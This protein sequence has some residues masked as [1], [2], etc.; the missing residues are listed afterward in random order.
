VLN[1]LQYLEFINFTNNVIENINNIGMLDNNE[2]V[3]HLYVVILNNNLISEIN[4]TF[5]FTE[6]KNPCGIIEIGLDPKLMIFADDKSENNPPVNS[7]KLLP[8]KSRNSRKFKSLNAI[9][10]MY[11]SLHE[12][13]LGNCAI[14]SLTR[15]HLSKLHL[16]QYLDISGNHIKKLSNYTFIDIHSLE[17]LLLSKTYIV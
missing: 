6:L 10:E 9:G 1:G 12:L 5:H 4:L 7:D 13:Q 2:I 16:V 17:T 11:E 8:D 3:Q 14:R 15:Q